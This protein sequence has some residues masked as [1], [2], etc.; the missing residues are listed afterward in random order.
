MQNE[1]VQQIR[2]RLREELANKLVKHLSL[3]VLACRLG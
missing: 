2:P 1:K 3:R